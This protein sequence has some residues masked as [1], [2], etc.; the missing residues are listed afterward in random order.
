M[1]STYSLP[2]TSHSREPDERSATIGYTISFQ[3]GRKPATERGSAS[4][5]RCAAVKLFEPTV[6]SV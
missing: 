1:R 3:I 6:R 2:S 5:G 4:R